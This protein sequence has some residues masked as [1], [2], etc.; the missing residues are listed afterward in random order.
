[1]VFFP[2]KQI[3][4]GL[5]I[6]SEGDSKDVQFMRDHNIGFVVNVSRNIPQTPVSGVEFTK[7]PV[8]DSTRY[9]DMLLSYWPVTVR[10]IDAVLARGKGVLVHCRAGM[11][12]S[13]ATVA[14][15]LMYKNGLSAKNAMQVIKNVK[16]ETFWPVPTFAI[17]LA[18]Y[19]KQ[20]AA[21]PK[22]SQ[23]A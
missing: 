16:N 8:D 17:A 14:A 4:P 23:R 3:I 18:K 13:A 15:Y 5:W 1:M 10:E 20:L 12:R 9:N 7:I 19:E 2:A 6:G 21:Y 22:N 11:Q